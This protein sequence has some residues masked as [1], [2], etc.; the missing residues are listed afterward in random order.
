M[1]LLNCEDWN[2]NFAIHKTVRTSNFTSCCLESYNI[3]MMVE[4]RTLN[5][6]LDTNMKKV[7]HQPTVRV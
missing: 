6:T 2:G 4:T 5:E 3:V 7:S 1:Q